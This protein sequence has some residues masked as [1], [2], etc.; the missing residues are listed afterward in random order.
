[1]QHWLGLPTEP[2]PAGSLNIPAV[3]TLL[4][5]GLDR[6]YERLHEVGFACS[7]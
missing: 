2:S 5:T 7:G 3:R 4:T 1:L 6:F